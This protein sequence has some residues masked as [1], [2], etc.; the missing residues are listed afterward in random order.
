MKSLSIEKMEEIEGEGIFGCIGVG[1]GL[2]GTAATIITIPATGPV[3]VATAIGFYSGAI[4]TGISLAGC[5]G[6]I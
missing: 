4:G 1:L 6:D 3:G 5:T 2:I